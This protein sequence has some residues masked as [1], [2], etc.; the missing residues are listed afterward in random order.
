MLNCG[1][2]HGFSVME[3]LDKVQE[4]AG[5]KLDIRSGNRR[6]GDPPEIVADPSRIQKLLDWHPIHDDLTE[7]VDSALRW[8]RKI[9]ALN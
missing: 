4:V 5:S 2:G 3:V 8:E 7:I 6:P 9:A 1:F